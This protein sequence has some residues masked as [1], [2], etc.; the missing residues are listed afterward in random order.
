MQQ[1][2]LTLSVPAERSDSMLYLCD[3]AKWISDCSKD[4]LKV[5]L[6]NVDDDAARWW[7]V[8]LATGEGWRAE[9][10]RNGNDYQLLWS[11]CIAAS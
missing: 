4:E 3:K 1:S 6:G 10:G 7:T 2:T 5:D 11:I 8:I 9:V